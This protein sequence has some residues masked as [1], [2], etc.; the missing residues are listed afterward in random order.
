MPSEHGCL[1]AK[2]AVQSS[3]ERK[4][5]RKKAE[6][7]RERWS[8]GDGKTR[9]ETVGPSG[10][11]KIQMYRK[12]RGDVSMEGSDRAQSHFGVCD[13]TVHEGKIA[14]ELPFYS[15]TDLTV[16]S[17]YLDTEYKTKLIVKKV[18]HSQKKFIRFQLK[19]Q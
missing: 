5:E 4:R 19:K 9:A 6:T 1:S 7:S 10:E 17:T 12:T 3:R 8:E 14:Q 16:A 13:K 2:L 11:I 18:K 15:V